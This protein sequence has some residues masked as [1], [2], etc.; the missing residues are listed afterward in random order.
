[1]TLCVMPPTV[2]AVLHL[3]RAAL[4]LRRVP[5]ESS[6]AV[7]AGQGDHG[8][9]DDRRGVDRHRLRDDDDDDDDARARGKCVWMCE[10]SYSVTFRV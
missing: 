3:S 2:L 1:M 6:R 7:A 8:R 5:N 10:T 9:H 4:V